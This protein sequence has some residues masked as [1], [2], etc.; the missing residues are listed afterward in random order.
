MVN[1]A[2]A[3]AGERGDFVETVS[4]QFLLIGRVLR[5]DFVRNGVA[6]PQLD[7][8]HCRALVGPVVT[9]ESGTDQRQAGKYERETR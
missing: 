6:G 1:K 9:L 3:V 7:A 4:D 5:A 8:A 2:N